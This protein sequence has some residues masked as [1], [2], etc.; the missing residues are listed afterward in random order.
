[1]SKYPEH[2]I[3]GMVSRRLFPDEQSLTGSNH[4]DFSWVIYTKSFSQLF[5]NSD[6]APFRY[7]LDIAN[8]RI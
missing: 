4:L 2:E 8:I 3:Y 6:L 7:P 1:M 5:R